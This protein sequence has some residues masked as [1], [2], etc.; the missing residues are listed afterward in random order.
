MAMR[1]RSFTVVTNSISIW[2]TTSKLSSTSLIIDTIISESTF[3][4]RIRLD[5][6]L[7]LSLGIAVFLAI[8]SA[9]LWNISS[10]IS[11]VF[12]SALVFISSTEPSM[13]VGKSRLSAGA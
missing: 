7:I 11:S 4:S 9:T 12:A 6:I 1:Q 13:R 10:G 5:V 8:I 2:E 3:N